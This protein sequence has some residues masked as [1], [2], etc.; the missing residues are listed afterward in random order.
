MKTTL[1]IVLTALVTFAL[2]LLI[3]SNGVFA[4]ET[5]SG[6]LSLPASVQIV[7]TEAFYGATSINKVVLPDG[8][9]EIRAR[10]FADS[11]LTEINLPDSLTVIDDTAFSTP[12][13][14]TVTANKGSWVYNWAKTKGFKMY[15]DPS[16]LADFV[17]QAID[18]TGSRITGYQGS[19][20]RVIIPAA[21]ADGRIVRE[22]GSMAFYNCNAL[23]EVVLPSTLEKLGDSAFANCE[24]LTTVNIPSG[25][26]QVTSFD[27]Y[28]SGPFSG[29]SSLT[30]VTIEEGMV[31][32]PRGLF[33]NSGIRV[34][35]IPDSVKNINRE[36]FANCTLLENVIFP[37]GLENIGSYCFDGCT[38]LKK[39][40]LPGTVR[41]LGGVL[42]SS[43]WDT[44]NG[45]NVF[46]N[47]TSLEEV[48]LPQNLDRANSAFS[49][50]SA[51]KTVHFAEGT[52]AL[53]YSIFYNCGL[54][55]INLP[56]TTKRIESNAFESC[57]SLRA[58]HLN[59]GLQKIDSMAFYNCNALT[60]LVLPSTLEVLG[61][62]SFGNCSNLETINI[63]ADLQTDSYYG[64][65]PFSGCSSLTNVTIEEGMVTLPRGLFANSGIRVIQIPDSVKNIN[66]EAFAN[67][68]LL[69]NVIFPDGLE[70]IGSYCFD[71]CTSL[72]KVNLPG[73]VR[74]LGGVLG[75]SGWDTSNGTNVFRNC[76]S[77]EEVTLPQNLDRANSAFSGCS[78]FNTV[79]MLF[80][81]QLSFRAL[82]GW[83][84]D[85]YSFSSSNPNVASVYINTGVVSTYGI[86]S[87]VIRAARDGVTEAELTVYVR[88]GYVDSGSSVAS[89]I[90]R[91]GNDWAIRWMITYDEDAS[92]TSGN[93]Q[94]YIYLEG[95]SGSAGELALN[96]SLEDETLMPWLTGAYGF[97][98]TDFN[99]IHIQ[100]SATNPFKIIPGQFSGYSNVRRAELTYV[101]NIQ[102]E[103]FQNC[104]GLEQFVFDNWLLEIGNA[105]FKNDVNL[106]ELRMSTSFGANIETIGDEA[107]MNTG[108]SSFS[109]N[110]VWRIGERAFANTQLSWIML[111]SQISSIGEDAFYG[112]DNLVINCYNNSIAH[113]YAAANNHRFRILVD[114]KYARWG[115][116]AGTI[117]PLE[118]AILNKLCTDVS[119]N[120]T[121]DAMEEEMYNLMKNTFPLGHPLHADDNPDLSAISRDQVQAFIRGTNRDLQVI[122]IKL[123]P[124]NVILIFAGTKEGQ[125]GDIVQDVGIALDSTPGIKYISCAMNAVQDLFNQNQIEAGNQL[126]NELSH[127][128]YNTYLTGYSLGGHIAVDVALHC[129]ELTEC[130]A[131][132]PPGRGDT[133]ISGSSQNRDKITNYINRY[134]SI[135]WVGQHVGTVYSLDVEENWLLGV[136]HNH[137]IEYTIDALGGY[138]AL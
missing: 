46:R 117:R 76:T 12:G 49:G 110:K 14:I 72:K 8:V 98:K 9:K 30:N 121:T 74:N 99:Y 6:V 73:T 69:E 59:E 119:Y 62:R 126:A 52:I 122:E 79:T 18:D 75:S 33:A 106:N 67:C 137:D 105:A 90:L 53:P 81:S 86:G 118:Y 47:C 111:D 23:T 36:A 107:F 100:G 41:N 104:T 125:F 94:L 123:D 103:A 15:D 17:F 11:T 77:L 35:Q 129:Q 57:A 27:S 96:S 109:F 113:H 7:D 136:I 71:G 38:S 54:E 20:G 124:K 19:G 2:C 42:G 92:G 48:T 102:V 131:I 64:N 89:G 26:Q 37:D 132:D 50:C 43:G 114:K 87:T 29:C 16:P 101:R 24:N 51:L 93:A 13:N 84:D 28:S 39:V 58:V 91:E 95:S 112:C 5:A 138:G 34:I 133:I 45:T 61:D 60:E 83:W 10:A 88:N 32:L 135:S 1:R 68:T 78:A 128:G 63:P 44:S 4:E 66:R 25:L 97:Q 82:F 56:E 115:K 21:D 130:V 40:N 31:T 80:P 85:S 116:Q 3:P 65:G 120:T 108:I 55:E 70:N 127:F 134:S 22:I